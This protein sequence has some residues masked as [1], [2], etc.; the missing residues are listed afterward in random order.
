MRLLL[1]NWRD[2][3]HPKAGGAEIMTLRL[4]EEMARRGWDIE[5]FSAAYEGAA[6]HERRGGIRYVRSGSQISVHWAAYQRYR[7]HQPYDVV[8]DEIN[9]I[10]FFTP[11]YFRLPQLALMFQ[12]AREVWFYEAPPPLSFAG[13]ALEPL[14]LQAY[15]NTPIASISPSSLKSFRA[16]GLRG[17]MEI[18]PISCD[19]EAIAQANIKN[20]GPDIVMVSRVTKSKRIHHGISAAALMASRGWNGNLHIVGAGDK[21]YL[22]RLQ[23]LTPEPLRD[24]II[25]HGRVSDIERK[26]LLTDAAVLWM[27]SHREGWGLVITEAARRGTPAVV[28]AVPGLC[29]AVE[30]GVTGYVTAPTPAALADAT[31]RLLSGPIDAFAQN[32]LEKSLSYTWGHSADRFEAVLRDVIATYTRKTV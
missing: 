26:T 10:P 2:P 13:Y 15:R 1:L 9:T 31:L 30:N 20:T 22:R 25:F 16:I 32:A 7:Q 18:V 23:Y 17:R 19:E 28:Y 8:V 27:T 4:L 24:R 21:D 6:N 12:L 3:W 14:Y 11:L 29:D 5:W